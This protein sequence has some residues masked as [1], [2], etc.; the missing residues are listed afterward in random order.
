MR[1]DEVKS[2]VAR[3]IRNRFLTGIG[4]IIVFKIFITLAIYMDKFPESEVF[5]PFHLIGWVI[6][7]VFITALLVVGIMLV[8][9]TFCKDGVD[10]KW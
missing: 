1:K 9:M 7:G 5:N 2:L 4:S 8:I 3:E 6:A 10:M